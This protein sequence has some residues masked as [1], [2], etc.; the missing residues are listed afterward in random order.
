MHIEA[1]AENTGDGRTARERCVVHRECQ[2][3]GLPPVLGASSCCCKLGWAATSSGSA[4]RGSHGP[5]RAVRRT[6][7]RPQKPV[8][9]C[10]WSGN[11]SRKY[12][13]LADR[14]RSPD[15]H[16]LYTST[17]VPAHFGA[18]AGRCNGRGGEVGRSVYPSPYIHGCMCM[19]LGRWVLLLPFSITQPYF[20]GTDGQAGQAAVGAFL[21]VN[22][23]RPQRHLGWAARLARPRPN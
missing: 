18:A 13:E 6:Q 5:G 9:V 16:T 7:P 20:Q 17:S 23:H 1:E 3:G 15:I 11:G 2:F 8:C 21:S 19:R 22:R 4:P 10:S 14:R 12:W